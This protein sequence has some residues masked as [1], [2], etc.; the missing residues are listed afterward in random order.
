M[1]PS[2]VT[3]NTKKVAELVFVKMYKL[4]SL[5]K[6]IISDYDVLFTSSFRLTLI[7]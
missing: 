1:V 3:Y 6:L 7:V 5:P 2:Q 4:H